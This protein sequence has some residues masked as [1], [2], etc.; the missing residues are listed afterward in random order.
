MPYHHH[1]LEN[2]LRTT[3]WTPS[4]DDPECRPFETHSDETRAFVA[5]DAQT[6]AVV[7]TPA[8]QGK[9]DNSFV[10]GARFTKQRIDKNTWI[11]TSIQIVGGLFTIAFF[12]LLAVYLSST[13]TNSTNCATKSGS[14][15]LSSVAVEATS[16][17]SARIGTSTSG[18]SQCPAYSPP[19]YATTPIVLADFKS[20]DEWKSSK[21]SN[22][23]DVDDGSWN[24][25]TQNSGGKC[26]SSTE[27]TS[28]VLNQVFADQADAV[29]LSTGSRTRTRFKWIKA[30][31]QLQVVNTIQQN[32]FRRGVFAVW[33]THMPE[34]SDAWNALWLY[35]NGYNWANTKIRGSSKTAYNFDWPCFGE[36]DSLEGMGLN[37]FPF[38]SEGLSASANV[39]TGTKLSIHSVPCGDAFGGV[40]TINKCGGYFQPSADWINANPIPPNYTV[41]DNSIF[42]N[43]YG[44]A[45]N[46]FC[47]NK[48]CAIIT[49]VTEEHVTLSF[50]GPQQSTNLETLM[51]NSNP[52]TL[53][54]LT[55]QAAASITYPASTIG[56]AE[57]GMCA[58][59]SS[60][61]DKG[62]MQC[63]NVGFTNLQAQVTSTCYGD[64]SADYE[65]KSPRTNC[66]SES[67]T[68]YWEFLQFKVWSTTTAADNQ[69]PSSMFQSETG[70]VNAAGAKTPSAWYVA[71]P[72]YVKLPST[73]EC[74]SYY[75]S[76][77]FRMQVTAQ[78]CSTGPGTGYAQNRLGDQVAYFKCISNA[79]LAKRT[80]ASCYTDS[81]GNTI[82]SQESLRALVYD[83]LERQGVEPNW[84]WPL[85]S[86]F[87]GTGSQCNNQCRVIE[88]RPNG[89]GA[90]PSIG[91]W[92]LA[93]RPPSEYPAFPYGNVMA[94]ASNPDHAWNSFSALTQIA[95]Q[96][97]TVALCFSSLASDAVV[98]TGVT[99]Q[100]T[101]N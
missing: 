69:V 22:V 72:L 48:G 30:N 76:L 1:S 25:N 85:L 51:D 58:V 86:W 50:F 37:G 61:G 15:S 70:I 93:V 18:L 83:L 63:N 71:Y 64:C 97:T 75:T 34:S 100:L 24:C 26:L 60:T 101:I 67:G 38:G 94:V 12:V 57:T 87:S 82:T 17:E 80:G 3:A 99:M 45:F 46:N 95:S 9:D 55:Q 92:Y 31:N 52:P 2:I 68:M 40:G 11:N 43:T 90:P 13:S 8:P 27:V 89:C 79:V 36:I 73:I 81:E 65:C 56:H 77:S 96:Q 53:E 62:P 88:L 14:D 47:K 98:D 49:L 16:L 41:N 10:V 91:R 39:Q 28:A 4:R 19:K 84:K 66:D 78:S 32:G 33:L 74:E 54:Q 23:W 35:G 42:G 44:R 20:A 5:K 6:V 21:S 29:Q 7:G 59:T